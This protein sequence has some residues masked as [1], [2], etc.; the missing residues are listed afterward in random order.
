MIDRDFLSLSNPEQ[1]KK[2]M[3]G[4]RR[5]PLSYLFTTFWLAF[6]P[7]DARKG[8]MQ[9]IR[10][11][12]RSEGE[13]TLCLKEILGVILAPLGS[14][15]CCVWGRSEVPLDQQPGASPSEHLVLR[16]KMMSWCQRRRKADNFTPTAEMRNSARNNSDSAGLPAPHITAIW[17]SLFVGMRFPPQI[18]RGI[19]IRIWIWLRIG[20]E[21]HPSVCFCLRMGQLG[22]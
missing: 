5:G 15:R 13:Q 14:L 10:R 1:N 4:T 11:Y 6:Y 12:H 20:S 17:F 8:C 18:S 7:T 19:R 9:G 3:K 16:R 2:A 22:D 21:Y